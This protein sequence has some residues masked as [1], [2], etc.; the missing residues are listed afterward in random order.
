MNKIITDEKLLR[1]KCV[2]AS[3][4]EGELIAARLF[5]VL[6]VSE[7]GVAIAANQIGIEKNVVVINVKEPIYL[8][9]P[10]IT[11][12]SGEIYYDEGCL[13]FPGKSAKTKRFSTI[14]V[15]ADNY[16]AGVCF[17]SLSGNEIDMLEC[18]AAQ[19]EI[20]HLNGITMFD[21]EVK[22]EPIKSEQKFG[23]NE[24]VTITKD[25]EK[26]ELKWKKAESLILSENWKLFIED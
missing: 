5:D 19:H 22:L 9:N 3:L 15:S 4:E 14:E 16:P 23:R 20:D 18:V 12:Q 26:R 25:E 10:K 7:A 13:S 11:N 17:T 8:I 1:N 6:S 21:R 2:D 24:K